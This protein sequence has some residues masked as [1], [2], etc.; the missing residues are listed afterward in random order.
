MTRCL[1]LED[2]L[3]YRVGELPPDEDARVEAHYFACERCTSRLE[4]LGH[5]REGVAQ[6][7]RDGQVTACV[8]AEL[9]DVAT[10]RD[11]VRIRVYE[12]S[13][14]E[15][16]LCTIAPEDDFVATRLRGEFEGLERVD[17]AVHALMRSTGERESRGIQAL[18]VDA[19]SGELV[20]L[21]SG[22]AIRSLPR[23][24][25]ELE[26]RAPDDRLL[27]SYALEHTPWDEQR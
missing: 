12:L 5:L 24:R 17:L 21:H 27:A 9:L 18:P 3:A 10:R 1:S 15:T 25:F 7:V 19:A 8:T 20:M 4:S 14:G 16:V 13:P 11:G 23:S 6:L 22:H 26:V 2:L